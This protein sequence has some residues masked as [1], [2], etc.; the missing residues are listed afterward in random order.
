VV[1]IT[2]YDVIKGHFLTSGSKVSNYGH[3][4]M[5]MGLDT[6]AYRDL[7]NDGVDN[8]VN[9]WR[10]G[11]YDLGGF[12]AFPSFLTSSEPPLAFG[13]WPGF[14]S[15]DFDSP[16]LYYRPYWSGSPP[17]VSPNVDKLRQRRWYEPP[18]TATGLRPME[19]WPQFFRR[20]HRH[21]LDS[22]IHTPSRAPAG[23]VPWVALPNL[24]PLDPIGGVAGIDETR[25][26]L[27]LIRSKD[28]REVIMFGDKRPNGRGDVQDWVEFKRADAQV[29]TPYLKSA[30]LLRGVGGPWSESALNTT[31]RTTN[32]AELVIESE[33]A[34]SPSHHHVTEFVTRFHGV[35]PQ[36]LGNNGRIVLECRV[37]P[38]NPAEVAPGWRG[39]IRGQV[40]IWN[41]T[42]EQW[43]PVAT[44][45]DVPQLYGEYR[46]HVD[47]PGAL[48]S[49]STRR[50]WDLGC[51]GWNG[52]CEYLSDRE[53]CEDG[54]ITIKFTHLALELPSGFSSKYDLV[55]FYHLDDAPAALAASPSEND[56][57]GSI[58][59]SMSNSEAPAIGF[60]A[61][62]FNFDGVQDATDA[63]LFTSAWTNGERRADYNADGEI[64]IDD[65]TQ[66]LAALAR[67]LQSTG[68]GTNEE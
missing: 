46:F 11:G 60:L 18:E 28:I 30:E 64:D 6:F 58:T 54:S 52:L 57:Q 25:R 66:F 1:K 50:E 59:T 2:C 39:Q 68:T 45:Q 20:T 13:M 47:D 15:G 14:A 29:Y 51:P 49:T 48:G 19:T 3:A 34:G 5:D 43:D 21:T 10:R 27:A 42:L 33:Y 36:S 9:V 12:G 37:A 65:L 8:P 26:T 56:G 63:T 23:V 7:T 61:A 4:N 41:E 38:N 17:V 40:S 32:P 16:D 35:R 22:I 62:D 53:L 31:L 67:A 44:I 24:E 55:M